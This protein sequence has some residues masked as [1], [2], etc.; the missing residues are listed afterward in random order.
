[1]GW[2][3]S[4]RGGGRERASCLLHSRLHP[5]GAVPTRQ[6]P[7]LSLERPPSSGVEALH[8]PREQQVAADE[9][10]NECRGQSAS[11]AGASAEEAAAERPP[12]S[13]PPP[14][15]PSQSRAG[16]CRGGLS[17]SAEVPRSSK[18]SLGEP[19]ARVFVSQL[20]VEDRDTLGALGLNGRF[21]GPQHR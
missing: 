5:W 9:L 10:P 21:W 16:P 19:A 11:A 17:P 12:R 1:M 15:S 6:E 18:G 3:T 8:L 14:L 20:Y 4:P 2:S 13:Q 7:S